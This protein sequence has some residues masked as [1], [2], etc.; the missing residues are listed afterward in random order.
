MR[1]VTVVLVILICLLSTQ[2]SCAASR[3]NSYYQA[4]HITSPTSKLKYSLFHKADVAL[5]FHFVN[6]IDVI[7]SCHDSSIGL[8]T[9][10][11]PP[12]IKQFLAT[13]TRKDLIVIWLARTMA[14]DSLSNRNEV[15]EIKTYATSLGFKRTVIFGLGFFE[16]DTA[17]LYD[18]SA[19]HDKGKNSALSSPFILKHP[20]RLH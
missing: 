16:A 19:T 5:L 12:S 8:P 13:S 20:D 14:W 1:L 4:T 3:S 18:S 6:K 9:Y 2:L 10:A 17:L 15:E 11:S 7:N